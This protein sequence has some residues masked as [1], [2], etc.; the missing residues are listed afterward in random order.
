MCC[1]FLLNFLLFYLLAWHLWVWFS[2][3]TFSKWQKTA[4][5]IL[6]LRNSEGRRA[7]FSLTSPKGPVGS[8]D[9]SPASVTWRQSPQG[10]WGQFSQG[11]LLPWD[12]QKGSQSSRKTTCPPICYTIAHRWFYILCQ[13]RKLHWWRSTEGP[14]CCMQWQAGT[15]EWLGQ[16]SSSSWS[17]AIQLDFLADKPQRPFCFLPLP[18][19]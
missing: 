16:A 14:K 4:S 13:M 9:H 10:G 12:V 6:T 7:F 5:L 18:Q 1:P 15:E 2:T 19:C 17:L 8:Q 11:R 3:A